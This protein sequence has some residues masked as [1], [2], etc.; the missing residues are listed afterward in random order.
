MTIAAMPLLKKGEYRLGI[1]ITR[2]S[3][4]SW[5]DYYM[6]L[7]IVFI[8]PES[9][10]SKPWRGLF[11][12]AVFRTNLVLLAIDEAHC[13]SEWYVLYALYRVNFFMLVMILLGVQIFVWHLEELAVCEH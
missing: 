4:S 11:S 2:L 3:S 12:S 5:V 8:S 10:T 6:C 13:I 1:Y 9:A 7:F